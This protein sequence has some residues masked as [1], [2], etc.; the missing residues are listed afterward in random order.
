MSSSAP[1]IASAPEAPR[2]IVLHGLWMRAPALALLQRRL[3]HA[4]MQV[5]AFDFA[6]A[7]VPLEHA[8]RRLRARL[9]ESPG[10]VH[11]VGHS[12]GGLVALRACTAPG[13]P[14]GRVVCLGSPL[15]GSATARRFHARGGGWLLG[16]SRELLEQ[17]LPAWTGGREVGVVA[18]TLSLGLG[19]MLRPRGGG[20]GDG[21]VLLAE[22]RIPGLTAHCRVRA[23]HTGL[24]FS[25]AAARQTVHFLRRGSFVES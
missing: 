12:L 24:L 8:I 2:V 17:G 13:L 9:A 25:A 6:S 20:P 18:G 19:R 15:A 5:E 14:P 7:R 21:T 10:T 4:G 23:S 16:G 11:L 22:T 1:P 3:R